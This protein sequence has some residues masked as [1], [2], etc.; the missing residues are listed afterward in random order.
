MAKNSTNGF[1]LTSSSGLNGKWRRPQETF[2][3]PIV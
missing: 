2:L 1:P 3:L